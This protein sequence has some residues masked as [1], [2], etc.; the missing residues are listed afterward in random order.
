MWPTAS[1][2]SIASSPL[3]KHIAVEFQTVK[4]LEHPESFLM[5]DP[6]V[7]LRFD[8]YAVG[9][10]RAAKQS[11]TLLRSVD[12]EPGTRSS[13]NVQQASSFGE[14]DKVNKMAVQYESSLF[15]SS[16]SELFSSKSKSF[17]PF[18]ASWYI[19]FTYS[20]YIRCLFLVIARI[21]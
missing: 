20:C 1:R 15:S 16:L 2:K 8:R 18:N 9:A 4:S 3:E 7:N 10:E 12:H 19:D 14:G 11:M 21:I 5:Q 17:S 13:L 6:K